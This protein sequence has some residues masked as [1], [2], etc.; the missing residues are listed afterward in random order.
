[1][2]YREVSAKEGT[3]V[4]AMFH[5]IIDQIVVMQQKKKKRIEDDSDLIP[6]LTTENLTE[7]QT[8]RR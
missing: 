5:T 4:E 2:A 8:D 3:N 6:P 7:G 1:M